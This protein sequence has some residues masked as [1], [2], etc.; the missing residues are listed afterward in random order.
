MR[1]GGIERRD[2]DT[3]GCAHEDLDALLRAREELLAA[4]RELHAFFVDL[5]RLLEREL[6]RLEPHHDLAQALEDLVEAGIGRFRHEVAPYRTR[7]EKSPLPE[8]LTGRPLAGK[9]KPDGG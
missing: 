3:A 8:R 2:L 1:G 7:N 6:S 4:P 9:L 5:Q